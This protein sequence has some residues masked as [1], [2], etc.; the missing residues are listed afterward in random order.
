MAHTRRSFLTRGITF[1][2]A[3]LVAPRILLSPST[4]LAQ[5]PVSN[6]ILVVV[7][8]NGGNDGLN[9]VIP[10]TDSLYR[11]ARPRLGINSRDVLPI[12]DTLGAN[13][14]AHVFVHDV[15]SFARLEGYSYGETRVT[16]WT[17]R[18]LVM[19]RPHDVVCVFEPVEDASS[20]L[21][22]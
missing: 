2:G 15:G 19:A 3:G 17:E 14:V 7:E 8:L 13:D 1:V 12:G 5:G 21:I 22:G 16:R 4:A 10:Y 11:S 20:A 18:A 6:R 9:T